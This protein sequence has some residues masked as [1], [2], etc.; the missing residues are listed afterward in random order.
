MALNPNF[1]EYAATTLNAWGH[2][3]FTDVFSSH[4]PLYARLRA[5]GNIIAGGL[6]LALLEPIMYPDP[7]GPQVIGVADAYFQ[8][9]P[10]ETTGFTNAQWAWC[11]KLLD[12]SVPQLQLDQ[13]GSD[14][15]R[16][17]W[18]DSVK[19]LNTVKFMENLNLDLWRSPTLVGTAGNTRQ[20]IGSLRAYLLNGG[21]STTGATA[22]AMPTGGDGGGNSGTITYTTAT[23]VEAAGVVT[24]VGGIERNQAGGGYW[25]TPISNASAAAISIQQLTGLYNMAVRNGD[26]PDLI[27]TTR[28]N[29]STLMALFQANQRFLSGKLDDAGFSSM[30]FMGADIVFDDN[31]PAKNTFCLNTNYFKWRAGTEAPVFESKPDPY[32]PIQH[33]VGRYVGQLISNNLGRVHSRM[34]NVGV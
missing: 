15:K 5:N 11:E 16:I 4:H 6:G 23:T 21:A 29:F 27:I 13:Q 1:A 9:S 8:T 20:N 17:A 7:G 24:N 34:Y 25:C 14:T 3:D 33:W 28:A 32:R 10:S 19:K 31:C 12:I 2:N 26:S 22:P 30:R 18:L